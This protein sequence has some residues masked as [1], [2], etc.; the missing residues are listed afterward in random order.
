MRLQ[1]LISAAVFLV[2]SGPTLAAQ[3]NTSRPTCN[4]PVMAAKFTNLLNSVCRILT[5]TDSE[6]STAQVNSADPTD[7]DDDEADDETL[8]DG[9]DVQLDEATVF[10]ARATGKKYVRGSVSYYVHRYF[11]DCGKLSGEVK[12]RINSID[13]FA[14]SKDWPTATTLAAKEE[15]IGAMRTIKNSNA[16]ACKY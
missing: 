1:S 6:A 5:M 4:R 13:S 9:G 7:G 12:R 14:T 3:G 10:T 2:A 11:Q 15:W 8:D 16:A